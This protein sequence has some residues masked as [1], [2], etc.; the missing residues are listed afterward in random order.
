MKRRALAGGSGEAGARLAARRAVRVSEDVRGVRC[1]AVSRPSPVGRPST[2][3]YVRCVCLAKCLSA[4]SP[5][6]IFEL[7][8][9]VAAAARHGAGG[10]FVASEV[11]TCKMGRPVCRADASDWLSVPWSYPPGCEVTWGTPLNSRAGRL[12]ASELPPSEA[13]ASRRG[14]IETC[15]FWRARDG[16]IRR[17]ATRATRGRRMSSPL[18]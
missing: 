4:P 6:H 3:L 17:P 13:A 16:L 11:G 10:A 7:H 1:V 2:P 18:G 5:V 12:R 15:P 8:P 14:R 9:P